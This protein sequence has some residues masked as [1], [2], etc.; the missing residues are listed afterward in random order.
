MVPRNIN[1]IV[2]SDAIVGGVLPCRRCGCRQVLSLLL[3]CYC[4][5]VVAL[6]VSDFN[7]TAVLCCA[8]LCCVVA[9]RE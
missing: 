7:T 9:V 6:L 5:A 4:T 2:A 3:V 1:S 8:V